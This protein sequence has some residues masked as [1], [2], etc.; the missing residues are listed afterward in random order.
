MILLF[1]SA[2]AECR[3]VLERLTQFYNVIQ[4]IKYRKIK[5]QEPENLAHS[6]IIPCITL[7]YTCSIKQFL[8]G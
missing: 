8:V 6:L 5:Y 7:P 1:T 2:F 4:L 3:R